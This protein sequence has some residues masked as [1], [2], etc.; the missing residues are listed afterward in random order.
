MLLTAKSYLSSSFYMFL[1]QESHYAAWP[2]PEADTHHEL[3]LNL[4]LLLPQFLPHWQLQ[5][6]PCPVLFLDPVDFIELSFSS[7]SGVL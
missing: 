2:E 3:A 6:A 4:K 1:R 7:L 5:S